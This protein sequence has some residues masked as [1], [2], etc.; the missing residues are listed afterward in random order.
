MAGELVAAGDTNVEQLE[1]FL[2][3]LEGAGWYSAGSYDPD[4]EI[5]AIFFREE[6]GFTLDPT[7]TAKRLGIVDDAGNLLPGYGAQTDEETGRLIV[8]YDGP[9]DEKFLDFL[10]ELRDHGQ[11][12]A[13]IQTTLG[14]LDRVAD[15][16]GPEAVTIALHP[17]GAE[18]SR[19]TDPA[20]RIAIQRYQNSKSKKHPHQPKESSST[21]L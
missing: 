17:T 8:G 10:D 19:M 18:D 3:L 4:R 13:E 15:I 9:G 2:D 1:S 14:E 21:K 6:N 7:T 12:L 20:L 16:I 5:S 11:E